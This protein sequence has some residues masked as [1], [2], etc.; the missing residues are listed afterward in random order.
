MV[1]ED[2]RV[3]QLYYYLK[4]PSL[5]LSNISE[6]QEN[7]PEIEEYVYVQHLSRGNYSEHDTWFALKDT[8][9]RVY[10]RPC[11]IENNLFESRGAAEEFQKAYIQRA[12]DEIGQHIADI[13]KTRQMF[14]DR[15]R[16]FTDYGPLFNSESDENA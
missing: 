14:I 10:L 1:K 12:I 3:G 13:D 16:A 6:W 2:L 9:K 5:V 4:T 15:Q 11:D 8:K 7:V